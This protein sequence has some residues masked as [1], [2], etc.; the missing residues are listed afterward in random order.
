MCDRRLVILQLYDIQK[1]K[2]NSLSQNNK[3]H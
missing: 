3:I 2:K 1:K